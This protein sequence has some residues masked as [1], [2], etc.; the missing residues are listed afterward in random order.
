MS[1][2]PDQL[3]IETPEQVAIRFPVAGIGSRFLALLADSL[4]Q[5]VA[6][7][8]LT[9]LLLLVISAAPDH[10]QSVA[11]NSEKWLIA[12][13]ILL[14]FILYWGYFT[15]FEAYWNGQT[16][17]KRICKLRV[18]RDSGRQITF[19]E[20]MTRNLLRAVDGFPGFYAV[21]IVAMLANRRNKRLGD[22]AAGTL[23]VHERAPEPPLWTATASRTI[24]AAVF[25]PVPSAPPTLDP[26]AVDLPADAV[27]RLGPDDLNLIDHFF[28]RAIDIDVAR[29]RQLAERV[30]QQITAKMGV[31]MPAGVTPERLLESAAHILR[32]IRR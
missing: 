7:A 26:H 25:T 29:R 28:A 24:T 16:P 6:Y 10:L 11:R 31:P 17:G 21:G 5:G 22:L 20:S 13:I 12:G 4:V 18:I 27:A 15:L 14:N 32:S 1:E 9:L 23:V 8:V 19:F 30:A 2:T 3:T